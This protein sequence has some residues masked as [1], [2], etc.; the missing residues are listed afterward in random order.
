MLLPIDQDIIRF[1][2]RSLKNVPSLYR[3]NLCKSLMDII[4]PTDLN[5]EWLPW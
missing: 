5:T 1:L 2:F 3:N 4:S